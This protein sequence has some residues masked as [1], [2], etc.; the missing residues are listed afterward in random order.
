MDSALEVRNEARFKEIWMKD[1]MERNMLDI[2]KLKGNWICV[3]NRWIQVDTMAV[4]SLLGGYTDLR[5]LVD[6][7]PPEFEYSC[8]RS[9]SQTQTHH[10]RW[11]LKDFSDP[12]VSMKIV[13]VSY[14]LGTFCSHGLINH[15]SQICTEGFWYWSFHQVFFSE[16]EL[17]LFS[18]FFHL[19]LCFFQDQ[20]EIY[21]ERIVS[22]L[23]LKG[24]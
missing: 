4:D 20:I 15:V 11:G 2:Q 19:P 3:K 7:D 13:V 1:S 9:V 23:L 14:K 21:K 24:L 12:W 8:H 6:T 22:D 17:F 18:I 16:K 10:L 5:L